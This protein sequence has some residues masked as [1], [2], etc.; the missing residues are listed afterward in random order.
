[1]AGTTSEQ[2]IYHW[3]SFINWCRR[4]GV[5]TREEDDWGAWWECW[6]AA[7]DEERSVNDAE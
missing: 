7:I 6:K 2:A 3:S 1:M 5:N 4:N